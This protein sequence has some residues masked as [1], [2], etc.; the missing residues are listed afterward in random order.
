MRSGL[1]C[2][3]VNKEP[4]QKLPE[5]GAAIDIFVAT[6]NAAKKPKKPYY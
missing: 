5:R 1:Y 2:N 4:D 6:Q 3:N